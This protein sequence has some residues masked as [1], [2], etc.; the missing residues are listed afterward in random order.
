MKPVSGRQNFRIGYPDKK[1]AKTLDILKSEP[2]LIVK[3]FLNFSQAD[4]AVYSKLYCRTDQYV[5]SQ[6]IGGLANG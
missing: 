2:I 6:T 5:F 1:T 4:N 3:R